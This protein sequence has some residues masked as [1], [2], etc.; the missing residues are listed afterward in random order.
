MRRYF[1]ASE[2]F[3]IVDLH[4]VCY[5]PARI[6]PMLLYKLLPHSKY[7]KWSAYITGVD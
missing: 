6:M 1:V 5:I 4:V 3:Q 7:G 2:M